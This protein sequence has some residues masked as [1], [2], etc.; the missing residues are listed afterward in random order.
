[1]T[2]LIGF[3]NL[4]KQQGPRS[5]SQVGPQPP[6]H[7]VQGSP[8][9]P[10]A[11]KLDTHGYSISFSKSAGCIWLQQMMSKQHENLIIYIKVSW[12]R[13][14]MDS[15]THHPNLCQICVGPPGAT[16]AGKCSFKTICPHSFHHKKTTTTTTLN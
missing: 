3:H 13:H 4:E 11:A 2:I 10:A 12:A 1:M 16:E 9:L 7:A 6:R 15:L 8:T 5:I 14:G